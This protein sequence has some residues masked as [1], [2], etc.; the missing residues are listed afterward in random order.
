[1]DRR[2][3]MHVLAMAGAVIGTNGCVTDR[4]PG[5]QDIYQ[6]KPFGQAR[7]LHFTDCHAQLLPVY[8]REPSVNLGMGAAYG[9]PPH[10]VGEALLKYADI[11][12]DTRLAHAFS[13]L[14]FTESARRYGKVG[15][16]AYL[17]SLVNQMR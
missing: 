14:D 5:K 4:Y 2:E 10:V 1:M 15:G 8:Y 17:R 11:S 7:L 16:F 3:F 12:K 6:A 13:Y 9:K